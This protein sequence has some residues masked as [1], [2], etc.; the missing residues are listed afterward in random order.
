MST[1]RDRLLK[2][3]KKFADFQY[4]IFTARYGQQLIDIFEFPVKLVLSPFT[5]AIDIAGSAPRG[6]GVPEL[7][8]KLSYM[9]IFVSVNGLVVFFE[10][11]VKEW[12][13]A[14]AT[15]GTY[16]IALELGKKVIC[17][18]N[19]G[20]CNGWQALR[21]TMC[22]GSGRV[23]Y[24]VKNYTLKSGEKATAE[25]IADAIADNRA[26]LVHLPSSI[27]LNAPL[28]SKDC[29]TCDGTGVMGCHE[30]KDK[31]QVRI[32]ADDIMEPPWKA[33]NVLRKMDYPYEAST[34]SCPVPSEFCCFDKL[35]GCSGKHSFDQRNWHI[36]H[37]MK[38]PSIAAFW[39]FT[40]PQVAGGFDFDDDVK[41]KIWWQYKESMRYDQLRDVVAKRKP[42]WEN[43][44]EA[45]ISIDPARAREDPVI[46]KNIPYYK[47]KKALEAEVMKLDPPPRPQNWG[48]LDLPLNASSWSKE[49]LKN[50]EKF[51]EMTVLLN[52]QREIAD[53][54][55]D[56]QWENRWRQ[57]RL[58]EMLEEKVRPYMQNIDSGILSQPIILPSQDQNQKACTS[59]IR[60]I[61]TAVSV[62]SK[63]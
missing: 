56:S 17:Q 54:I 12:I 37:S 34:N 4:K 14:V 48:E 23:H 27:N 52:A 18:R 16:D 50:P 19:C 62:D 49:D 13:L 51:Y 5:L 21:C 28:P 47:A 3:L 59:N 24:Q 11:W 31:L 20:T 8:S 6:F 43:L 46:V 39:L 15:L 25:C 22:R 33:Y 61:R 2:N 57:Q 36:V 1:G 40:L 44:Q 58:N 38:D 60:V 41:K 45:L 30:C 63:A 55:L 42:G 32:S 26:E 9:S 29:P 53:K 10:F 7:V 35:S